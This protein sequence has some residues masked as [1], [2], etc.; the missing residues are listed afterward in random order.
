MSLE[1][2]T[3]LFRAGVEESLRYTSTKSHRRITKATSV[4]AEFGS[5]LPATDS[6]NPAPF[7]N[8]VNSLFVLLDI[9][10]IVLSCRRQEY[11]EEKLFYSTVGSVSTIADCISRKLRGLLMVVSL[12]CIKLELLGEGNL[13]SPPNKCKEKLGAGSRKKKGRTRNPKRLNPAPMNHGGD[14]TFDEPVKVS[15][16]FYRLYTRVSF[17]IIICEES[18]VVSEH[19]SGS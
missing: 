12:D 17:Y 5:I 10:T 7:A 14:C 4:D 8:I 15:L 13:R 3:W 6:S 19:F 18:F 16:P 2:E 9:L 1:D 11:D